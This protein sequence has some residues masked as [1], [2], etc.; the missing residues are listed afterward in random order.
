[1]RA[2]VFDQFGEPAEVLSLREAPLPQPAR[3]EVRVRMLASPVNPSD[4]MTVRGTYS[5]LPRL[6]A[7]PG[8]EG[9]GVVEAAGGG[10]LAK[11]LVGKR[12]AALNS[13]GGDWQEHV[14]ISARQAIPISADIPIEQAATF[15]VNP[16][17]AYVMTRRVLKVPA[18]AWLL[19]TAA[20]SAL[21]RMVIR[22]G[23]RYGFRTI[24]VVRRAGQTDELKALGADEVIAFDPSTSGPE[25]LRSRVR[26]LTRERGVSFALDPVGGATGSAA[27]GCLGHCGRM[28]VFGTLSGEPLAFSPRELMT[29]G[30]SVEGFWLPNFMGRLRLPGKLRLVR[31]VASLLRDGTLASEIGA[32]FPLERIV[33]AVRAAEEPGRTGK[34]LLHIADASR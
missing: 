5:K 4:L 25:A 7:T 21:G 10:L 29:P 22:L 23:R 2:I 26:E 18:G 1:M 6:P 27:V 17:T 15:F 28:L 11:L 30:A 31:Q 9:V 12:V 32:T 14:V 8:Y 24:N 3:G 13:Y 34:V 16:T 19:Q 20:G 33:E